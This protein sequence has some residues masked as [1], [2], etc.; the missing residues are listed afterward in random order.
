MKRFL[1]SV[2]KLLAVCGAFG[3]GGVL[4]AFGAYQHLWVF[5]IPGIILIALG[6][7]LGWVFGDALGEW[8]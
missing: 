1:V 3:L 6:L 2:V 8:E 7:G 5:F 4:A